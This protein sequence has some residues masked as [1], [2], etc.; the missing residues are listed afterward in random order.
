[1]SPKIKNN[2][3]LGISHIT[4]YVFIIAIPVGLIIAILLQKVNFFLYGLILGIPI[5]AAAILILKIQKRDS[6]F[7]GSCVLFSF[8]QQSILRIFFIVFITSFIATFFFTILATLFLIL[9][10]FLYCII[11]I[12]IF[13]KNPSPRMIIIEIVL[14]L[15]ILIYS[16]TLTSSYYFGYTDIITHASIATITSLTGHVISNSSSYSYFPLY[17]IWIASGAIIT[18]FNSYQTIIILTC[19]VF[20]ISVIFI[21]FLFNSV[22]KNQQIALLTCLLYSSSSII[23]FFGTYVITRTMAF[24]GFLILLYFLYNTKISENNNRALTFKI[25]AIVISVYILLVHQ[26]STPMILLLLFILLICEWLVDQQKYISTGFMIF[27]ISIFISYWLFYAL[28]FTQQ[29][30]TDNLN[31]QAYQTISF[32]PTS[33]QTS[34]LSESLT[35]LIN[36]MHMLIFIFFG[37]IGIVYIIWREKPKYAPVFGLFALLTIVFYVPSPL[38]ALWQTMILLNFGRFELLI[39]PFMVLM[40][41]GGIWVVSKY[42]VQK[43]VPIIIISFNILFIFLIFSYSSLGLIHYN[44]NP[45]IRFSFNADELIGYNFIKKNIPSDSNIFSDYYTSRYLEK[46]FFSIIITN[47]SSLS[48]NHGYFVIA[49]KQFLKGGL[50]FSKGDELNPEGGIYSYLPINDNI[51]NLYR[52]LYSKNQIYSSNSLEIYVSK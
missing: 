37:I 13:S 16:T 19:P 1:M 15:T 14:T 4:P 17:H 41:A 35:F 32:I 8:N 47:T 52:G 22:I 27:F 39:S 25:L 45:S 44:Q 34:L 3:L 38:Q 31:P 51:R 50:E 23:V 5:L 42:L 33:Y 2:V 36:D 40:M 30:I 9:I 28:S 49:K 20:A 24:I 43:N 11:L 7:T 6:D 48:L 10:A 18:G 29:I 21:Y 12:Q 26:V 46:P